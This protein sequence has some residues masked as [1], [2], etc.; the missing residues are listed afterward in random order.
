[1]VTTIATPAAFWAMSPTT[2]LLGWLDKD[3]GSSLVGA[4]N[5]VEFVSS[6]DR[7]CGFGI[8]GILEVF[9]KT[10]VIGLQKK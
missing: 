1:M 5:D 9:S 3:A 4:D 6:S 8:L 2:P 10:R 7:T